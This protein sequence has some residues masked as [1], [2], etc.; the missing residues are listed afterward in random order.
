MM[1]RATV[2]ALSVA[3][4]VF[5][6]VGPAP[7]AN[8]FAGQT[9][10]VSVSSAGVPANATVFSGVLSAD[11]RYV[12]FWTS[13]TNLLESGPVSGAHVYRHDRLSGATALISVSTS[14]APGNNVSRDPS[15]SADGRFVVF[16]SFATDLVPGGTNGLSQVFVR[17]MQTNTT[18]LASADASGAQGDRMRSPTMADMSPSHRPRR[19]SSGPRTARSRST[20]RT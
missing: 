19:T 12:V 8:A 9:T 15:V 10:R 16:S 3:A 11:G 20:S 6:V 13:A 4:M 1:K 2:V 14:G 18:R 5:S 7:I 17:D